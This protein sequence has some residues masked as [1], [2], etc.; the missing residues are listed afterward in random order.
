MTAAG[1]AAVTAAVTAAAEIVGVTAAHGP[2]V[3]TVEGVAM[4]VAVRRGVP[5]PV[6][7]PAA[8]GGHGGAAAS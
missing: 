1:T 2:G 8:R 5:P 3:L 6:F 7:E 4:L